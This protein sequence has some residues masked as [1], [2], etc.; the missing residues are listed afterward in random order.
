MP[1]FVQGVAMIIVVATSF[2][3]KRRQNREHFALPSS[4]LVM[5]EW[6]IWVRFGNSAVSKSER[7]FLP[8][9][10]ARFQ[11][12]DQ[13]MLCETNSHSEGTATL[14]EGQRLKSLMLSGFLVRVEQIL[15][16]GAIIV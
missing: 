14:Y 9:P 4:G 3:I 15:D 1:A 12:V 6:Q 16:G 11:Y 7:P 8:Y 10:F 2:K 5:D 13:V